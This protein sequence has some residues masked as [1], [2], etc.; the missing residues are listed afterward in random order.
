MST[1]HK[2]VDLETLNRAWTTFVETEMVYERVQEDLVSEVTDSCRR[3]INAGNYDAAASLKDI[4]DVLVDK[5]CNEES[6][7]TESVLRSDGL[8]VDTLECGR[9]RIARAVFKRLVE[10]LVNDGELLYV[11]N[12][13]QVRS[14]VAEMARYFALMRQR[15]TDQTD[16]QFTPNLVKMV[17]LASADREQ[18]I[19][20]KDRAKA[21]DFQ[22]PIRKINDQVSAEDTNPAWELDDKV[23]GGWEDLVKETMTTMSRFFEEGLPEE[24]DSLAAFQA[25]TFVALYLN[26][27][28]DRSGLD[29]LSHVVTASTGGGKT[30]AFMFPTLAYCLTASKAGISSNK[31]V[32]TY[33]RTDLC[34]NQFERAFDYITELN[35]IEGSLDATFEEAPLTLSIQHG[36]RGDVTLPCPHCDGT[37]EVVDEFKKPYFRCERSP[38]HTIRYASVDRSKPADVIVTT[39]N[40]LHRRLMD[41]YGRDAFW[42]SPYPPKFLVL[43]EVH[44]YTD[45]A[46]M[47]VAN[48]VRRFKQGLKQRARNQSPTLVASSA[49]INNAEDFT[50]RI[51]DTDRAEEISPTEDEKDTTSREHFVFVKATD[52]RDVVVPIGDSVYRPRDEWE[53]VS[54]TTASNLSCM[55]QIAFG[56]FHTMRKERAGS[57]EGLNVNKDRVLGFVDSID[58][59]SR[60]GGYVQEAEE[61]GL[62]KYRFP[63]A[64]LG[65][66]GN[67]PDCP[68]NL[69]RGA[70]DDEYDEDAVCE[71]VVPNENINP[72]PVYQDGECWWTMRDRELD[73]EDMTVA[74]HRSGN[75]KIA[76]SER[77]V[78]DDW[79]QL[80]TTSALEVGFDHASIIGTFQ[81]RAPRSVPG[82]L[83][84]KGRGGRD[85]ADEPITVVVLGSTPTDSYYF[86]HSN[87]LSEPRDDHLKIPLDENNRFIRA[88]HMTAAIMDYFNISETIDAKRAFQGSY[89]NG[90]DVEYLRQCFDNNRI[91]LRGWL[92]NAFDGDDDE[93]EEVLSQFDTFLTSVNESVAPGVDET[94]YWEFFSE[95]VEQGDSSALEYIDELLQ[96]LENE[97]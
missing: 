43:D 6:A 34:D 90:P 50:R 38:E 13:Q 27:V 9:E 14:H 47:N 74:I 60:L 30:E 16:Y 89:S 70:T 7:F 1:D 19:M 5:H 28:T 39:Q 86:H 76:G 88:E 59:V 77:P 49:T 23:G 82:F 45:Q 2:P 21:R 24:F 32:L 22:T 91:E 35:R 41:Q 62:F 8:L 61:E 52:P 97:R 92:S 79:D 17:K 87:Y 11:Y 68:R 3:Q 85:A 48:V 36:S 20:G 67:N 33:P 94:P 31:A 29:S 63:D 58:S 80:I 69:F 15:L 37:L 96:E 65:E 10:Q 44:I 46:G 25:R 93:I 56:F 84:R 72:C 53:N 71:S 95:M 78:G 73:L 40:S 26:S 51:F 18:P 75:T 81:Y 83:Q 57:R 64:I 12:R 55:I 42:D 54:K 66:R 4:F